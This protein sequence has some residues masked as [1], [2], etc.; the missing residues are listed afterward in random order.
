MNSKIE[1]IEYPKMK[2][3]YITQIGVN[4]IDNA[5][6]RII[7]W[8]K[9]KGL[10]AKDDSNVCRVFHDSFK[11]TDAEKVRMSIGVRTNQY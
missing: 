8:A 3:A 1:I 4:G 2:L 11:V 5:F 10:L 7:K 6:Q 9:P